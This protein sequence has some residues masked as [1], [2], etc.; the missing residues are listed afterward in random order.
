MTSRI[1]FGVGCRTADQAG[2]E[3]LSP[4]GGSEQRLTGTTTTTA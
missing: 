4:L 3:H 1:A 2:V